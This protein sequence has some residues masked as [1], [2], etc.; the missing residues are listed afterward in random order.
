[1]FGRRAGNYAAQYVEG[2]VE[3]GRLTLEHVE[4]YIELLKEA[5]IPPER[6]APMLLPDYRGKAVLARMV[7][8]L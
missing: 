7:D 8:V 6:K 1:V 3:P 5:G 2:G 4:A